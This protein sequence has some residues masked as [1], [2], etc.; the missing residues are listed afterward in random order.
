MIDRL[1]EAKV[2]E[3]LSQRTEPIAAA[4]IAK[5][6][7]SNQLDVQTILASN[8]GFKKKD[9]SR[10]HKW[11]FD[12]QA[13]E[14]KY[15]TREMQLL[16]DIV[17]GFS[18]GKSGITAIPRYNKQLAWVENASP[19]S[20][21]PIQLINRLTNYS[22]FEFFLATLDAAQRRAV[23]FNAGD[24]ATENQW[25]VMDSVWVEISKILPALQTL[26]YLVRYMLTDPRRGTPEEWAILLTRP[27]KRR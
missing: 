24:I 15:S 18:D 20:F 13:Y 3:Y 11:T 9:R 1:L 10:P 25:L 26:N 8:P 7:N 12:P 16:E 22:D 5:A 6:I 4:D 21:N 2:I 19:E 27:A 17:S 23:K 14:V